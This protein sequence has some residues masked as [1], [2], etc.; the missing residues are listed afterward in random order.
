M[1]GSFSHYINQ[2]SSNPISTP[3][4]VQTKTKE[5]YTANTKLWV[6]EKRFA[7]KNG[8]VKWGK[9]TQNEQFEFKNNSR[10][11]MS[12]IDCYKP[13]NHNSLLPIHSI[14]PKRI[15]WECTMRKQLKTWRIKTQEGSAAWEIHVNEGWMIKK[16][17]AT[18]P[19]HEGRWKHECMGE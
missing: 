16:C 10:N 3:K 8:L 9:T 5:T 6:E 19:K 14:A 7:T 4:L 1:W 13:Q 12:Q 18:P 11:C 2:A 15:S 17:P